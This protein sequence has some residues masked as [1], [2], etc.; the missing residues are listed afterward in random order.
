M[1]DLLKEG[2]LFPIDEYLVPNK[3]SRYVAIKKESRHRRRKMHCNNLD[4]CRMVSTTGKYEMPILAPYDGMIPNRFIP[5]SAAMSTTDYSAGVHFFIDD[6]QFERIWCNVSRYVEKLSKYGCVIGPDFSQYGDMSYPMRMWNCYRN[7]VVSSYLQ[8]HGV[9]IV[10][11]VTWSLPDSYDYCFDG[12]PAN[13]IIAINCTS[14]I[15][16]NLSK[17]LWYKGYEEALRRLNPKC[18]IRYGTKMP[19]ENEDI[20]YYFENERLKQ[21]KHGR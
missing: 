5:F 16:S 18:I 14:I 12:I 20:S 10:P 8:S 6:H 1:E 7:K 15:S 2:L 3:S 17:Y 13:S 21:L 9:K 19:G 4:I 11:N